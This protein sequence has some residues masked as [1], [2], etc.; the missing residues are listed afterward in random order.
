MSIAAPVV[1]D[2]QVESGVSDDEL[3]LADA[4]TWGGLLVA[5]EL[6]GHPV[7]GHLVRRPGDDLT[8]RVR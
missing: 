8:I 4:E 3:L 5:G 6:P 1:E 7:V 2:R